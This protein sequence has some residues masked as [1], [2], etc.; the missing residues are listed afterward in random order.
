MSS[1]K[2]KYAE[3]P[4]TGMEP[5]CLELLEELD[6]FAAPSP[7]P[8][9]AVPIRR[10]PMVKPSVIRT[11]ENDDSDSEGSADEDEVKAVGVDVPMAAVKAGS[12]G[13]QIGRASCRER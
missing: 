3:N 5:R 6:F 7:P 9:T 1:L 11:Q 2:R 4:E 13:E 12:D 8:R 10:L